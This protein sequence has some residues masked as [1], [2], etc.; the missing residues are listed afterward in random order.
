VRMLAKEKN[1]GN[2]AALPS[3]DSALL[4]FARRGIGD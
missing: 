3:C 4:Q 2:R 1:I